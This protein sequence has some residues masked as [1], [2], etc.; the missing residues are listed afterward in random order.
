[1]TTAK[2]QRATAARSGAASTRPNGQRAT[3]LISR[4]FEQRIEEQSK[5]PNRRK[6]LV[7]IGQ[8]LGERIPKQCLTI[9]VDG[10]IGRKINGRGTTSIELEARL[11]AQPRAHEIRVLINSPG[12]GLLEAE[13]MFAALRR[14]G[15]Y[16]ITVADGLCAS[17]A[18]TVLLAGDWREAAPGAQI[19]I[20]KAAMSASSDLPTARA[21]GRWTSD[22][23]RK[24]ATL[25]EAVDR[26]ELERFAKR[27]GMP[28]AMLEKEMRNSDDAAMPLRRA[29]MLNIV[30]AMTGEAVWK[31]GR[32]YV[33]PRTGW[34][35][36]R[37]TAGAAIQ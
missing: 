31:G 34:P 27:T 5:L 21:G 28:I 3:Q 10:Q 13:R 4:T 11:A 14:H 2:Q 32:P 8:A 26:R 12:G 19:L 35:S 20:H 7:L 1:L 17:A 9:R 22:K 37:T 36:A 25:L 18:V 6:A 30:H 23:H 15:A 33:W 24:I 16:I 29:F